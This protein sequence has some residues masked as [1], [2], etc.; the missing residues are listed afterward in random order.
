MIRWQDIADIIIMSFLVYQLYVWFKHTKA[1]QVVIGLGS[2]GVVYL[3]T[4]NLGFFMTSWILQELGTVIFVLII[5]IFQSEIRQALYRIS[6]LRRIFGRQDAGPTFDLADLAA[7]IFSL[8]ATNTGAIIAFQRTEP[9]D[10]YLSNG[11]PL[12]SC[13][14]GQLIGSVFQDGSPLHD[15]ALVIRN[16]RIHKASCHLPLSTNP[17]IPQQYGT[18]HRAALG[19][20]EKS[21]CAVVIV[22]EERGEVSLA[23][24]GELTR[25]ETPEQLSLQLTG[26]LAQ[27]DRKE[28]RPSLFRRIFNNFWPKLATVV[29]VSLIWLV[30]TAREGEIVTVTAPVQFR[31]LPDSL[32]LRNSS[33]D[34]V[35]LQLKSFSSLISPPKE[36]DIVSEVDLSKVR[37][38]SNQ[39]F[40][41]K[42]DFN[43]PSGL[44]ITK[45]K[46]VSLRVTIEK[47]IRKLVRVE[48]R[49]IGSPSGRL[50]LRKVKLIPSMVM[51]E[52]PES[53]MSQTES[54]RTEPIS[55]PSVGG[56]VQLEKRLDLPA[57]LRTVYDDRVK[58]RV[59]V[60]R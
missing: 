20:S 26:L 59:I 30:I 16:D 8:A 58:V 5:V 45:I 3:I 36:G 46:P 32:L 60:G 12:D 21:D 6:P 17:D 42:E 40:F 47:K 15:G 57:P 29:L 25:I 1:L 41:R 7:S 27:P 23:L 28:S 2:L 14:T 9:I 43:L 38:G 35:E 49:I 18:R 10:E 53:I 24:S 34:K 37:E 51:I 52:G 4:R 55:L 54:V 44:V 33:A 22:S 13:I 50:R 39:L 19:L 56:N 11:V 48:A 31:N